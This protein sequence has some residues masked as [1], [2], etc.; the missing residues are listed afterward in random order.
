L[1]IPIKAYKVDRVTSL[2][3][4]ARG[5]DFG[6]TL[7]HDQAR[8]EHTTQ[9][10]VRVDDLCHD[11]PAGGRLAISGPL[12]DADVASARATRIN[13]SPAPAATTHWTAVP[14]LIIHASAWPTAE[15]VF[16]IT[17]VLCHDV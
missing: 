1:I 14:A 4:L 5:H 7:R 11:I 12:S 3:H 10:R 16:W 17:L 6:C 15:T 8:S 13:C 2:V 9:F